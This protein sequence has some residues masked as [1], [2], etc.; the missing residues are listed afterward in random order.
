MQTQIK[1]AVFV[2]KMVQSQDTLDRIE[3][4]KREQ[5]HVVEMEA[6]KTAEYNKPIPVLMIACNRVTV[7]R[8]LGSYYFWNINSYINSV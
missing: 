6:T 2:E 5:Q 7:A 8:A 3:H 4:V 1:Q